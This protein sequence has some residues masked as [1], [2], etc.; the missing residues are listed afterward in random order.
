MFSFVRHR[1]MDT[2]VFVSRQ[3]VYNLFVLF[4]AG[5]YLITIALIGYL[6]KYHLIQQ[7]V[8]QFL[9]AEVFMY[10]ALIDVCAL[11]LRRDSAQG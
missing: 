6:V 1:L 8:T 9:V 4:V 7:G 11:T 5:A 3:V 2:D 10:V